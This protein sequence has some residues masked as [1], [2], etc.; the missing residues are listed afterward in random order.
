MRKTL[1]LLALLLLVVTG[2]SFGEQG[3]SNVQ[4]NISMDE[5]AHTMIEE[6]ITVYGDKTSLVRTLPLHFDTH[7]HVLQNIKV[8]DPLTKNPIKYQVIERANE[9]QLEIELPKKGGSIQLSYELDFQKNGSFTNERIAFPIG[10]AKWDI[11][12]PQMSFTLSLPK[13]MNLEERVSYEITNSLDVDSEGMINTIFQS[14]KIFGDVSHLYPYQN[15]ELK[16]NFPKNYFLYDTTN[17]STTRY[18]IIAV[19][20]VLISGIAFFV[21]SLLRKKNIEPLKNYYFPK[22]LSILEVDAI[23]KEDEGRIDRKSVV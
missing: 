20:L 5:N 12:V 7:N 19:L 8:I 13:A 11:Y 23:V 17:Y 4:V 22:G 10:D 9:K 1:C 21:S 15:V 16:I 6:L 18:I 14:N 2:S 3:V